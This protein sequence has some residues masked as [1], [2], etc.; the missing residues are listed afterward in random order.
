MM[1]TLYSL[2][3]MNKFCVYSNGVDLASCLPSI[4]FLLYN[5]MLTCFMYVFLSHIP[6]AAS[7]KYD[8]PSIPRIAQIGLKE[9]P[10]LLPMINSRISLWSNVAQQISFSGICGGSIPLVLSLCKP[11]LSLLLN[12]KARGYEVLAVILQSDFSLS[13]TTLKSD[14]PWVLLSGELMCLLTVKKDQF[15]EINISEMIVNTLSHKH[16]QVKTTW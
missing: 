11:A 9:I 1:T 13:Q 4:L 15:C 7:G 3:K 12:M 16:M 8:P 10:P 14:L 2:N 6:Y 5:R